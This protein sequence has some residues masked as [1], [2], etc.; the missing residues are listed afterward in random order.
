MKDKLTVQEA[1]MYYGCEFIT[2]N[3]QGFINYASLQYFEQLQNPKLL[4]RHLS[5]MTDEED[6]EADDI[7]YAIADI[8]SEDFELQVKGYAAVTKY[9]ISKG[10]DVFGYIQ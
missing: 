2:D 10:F 3:S 4:L 5:D 6:T 9:L 8:N 7:F 1:A